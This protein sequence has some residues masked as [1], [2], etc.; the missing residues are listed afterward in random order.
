VKHKP[1]IGILGCGWLGKATAKVLLDKGYK[2]RGSTTSGNGLEA[3]KKIGVKPFV[4]NLKPESLVDNLDDFLSG[5]QTLV[6]AIPPKFRQGE[7]EL[8]D[9]FK[10]MFKNYDFSSIQKLIYIS[11]TGVFKDGKDLKY[12]ED[13][14]PNNKTDRG[15]YLIV[16]EDFILNQ[17]TIED[18][19]VI[20][21][22]GLIKHGGRHPVYYLS[23]K[24]GI[25]NPNAPVNLIEQADAV[26]LLCKLIEATPI[27]TF[28]HGV[29]PSHPK[30]IEY[31]T[32]KAY[33]LNLEIPEFAHTEKYIGKLIKSDL[34]CKHL[35]FEFKSEI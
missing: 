25:K 12:D 5:L 7:T 29:Y 19:Y 18:K 17:N 30:R 23:G 2:V 15:Q 26:N 11:S 31:Y 21:Y 6:I 13:S 34:T 32:S 22:G 1:E 20:R 27:K 28:F 24:K 9:S 16:L 4:V 33:E 10:L 35:N 14:T 8:L 3:L